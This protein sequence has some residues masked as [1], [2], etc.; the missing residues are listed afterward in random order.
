MKSSDTASLGNTTKSASPLPAKYAAKIRRYALQ[1]AA[2]ALMPGER[3]SWC[4]RRTQPGKNTVPVL[5]SP[6]HHSAH[7]GHVMICGSVWNCPVCAAKVSERRRAELK[8][9][10]DAAKEKH[11]TPLLITFTLSHQGIKEDYQDAYDYFHAEME[12]QKRIKAGEVIASEVRPETR[13]DRLLAALNDATRN[14]RSGKAW[15]SFSKRFGILHAVTALEVTFGNNGWHPHKHAL[16]F[17]SLQP[18]D[19]D[20][21][22]MKEWLHKRYAAILAKHGAYAD[23][24]HGVDVRIGNAAAGDYVAKWSIE[25]ELSKASSKKAKAGGVSPFQLL[26]LYFYGSEES[27]RLFVPEI[28]RFASHAGGLFLVY[29]AAMKGKRQLVWSAGAR[30]Y[31]GLDDEKDDLTLAQEWRED[32]IILLQLT[33]LQWKSVLA[34]D[35]RAEVLNIAG[36]G[37]AYA[38]WQELAKYGILASDAQMDAALSDAPPVKWSDYLAEVKK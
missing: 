32:A 12:R 38:V 9:A 36:N 29:A 17:T 8:K 14:M 35:I 19:I 20:I 30:G 33:I 1:S 15:Q 11:L 10:L 4:M 27:A 28:A 37:K 16:F 21:E 24:E 13:L 6:A 5:H 2:A 22:A 34:N 7:Y 3:V 23:F 26:E 18:G 25:Q 31:L